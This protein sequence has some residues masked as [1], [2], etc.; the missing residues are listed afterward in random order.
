MQS[1]IA[2]AVSFTLIAAGAAFILFFE[3]NNVLLGMGW[4]ERIWGSL[5]QSV[6]ARTAGFNTLPTG[7][8]TVPALLVLVALMF[9]GASPGSTGGGIKTCTFA[10][11]AATVAG[12][13]RNKRRVMMFGRSIPRNVVRESLVI[14]FLGFGWVFLMTLLLSYIM[15]QGN[16]GGTLA[17]HLF[18][19]AS[20][21]GTVGLSTGITGALNNAGKLCITLT[22]FAGRLGPL[23][24]ALAIAFRERKDVFLYPEENMM[25]G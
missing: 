24:L 8:F 5:F 22:M 20:A 14:F 25:V 1:K 11:V 15:T 3:R 7:D 10:V 18:E 21:F 23:T 13:I 16:N 4:P 6:T 9:I 17:D 12:M 19:V 2:L